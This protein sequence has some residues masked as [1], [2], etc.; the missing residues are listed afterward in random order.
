[1]EDLV[2]LAILFVHLQQPIAGFLQILLVHTQM[3][4][5]HTWKISH[6][7]QENGKLKGMFIEIK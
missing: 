5:L 2:Q 3:E 7:Q 1:M 4:T 6:K